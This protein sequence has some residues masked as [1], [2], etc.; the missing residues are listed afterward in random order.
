MN[1]LHHPTYSEE[2]IRELA[3]YWTQRIGILTEVEQINSTLYFFSTELGV[4]RITKGLVNSSLDNI[5]YSKNLDTWYTSI[6]VN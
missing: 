4:F 2:S 1:T 6:E 5:A 3:V